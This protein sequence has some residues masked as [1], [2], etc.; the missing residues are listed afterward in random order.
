[1][2]VGTCELTTLNPSVKCY[3]ALLPLGQPIFQEPSFFLP[4]SEGII[5]IFP[6]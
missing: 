3:I 1:M 5:I 6:V 4:V 2:C